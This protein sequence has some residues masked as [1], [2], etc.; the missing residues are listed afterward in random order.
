MSRS[1]DL[2]AM[3]PAWVALVEILARID[4]EPY[5][6][7]VGRI[8]FQKIAYFATESGLPTGLHYARGSYGPFAPDLKPLVTRLVNNGLI[9]EEE[10]GRMFVVKPGPTYAD[11]VRAYKDDLER[12]EPI[13]E[14]VVDLF[15]R[16]RTEQAEV[17]A[18]AHFAATVLAR[19]G[20][21]SP[22]ESDVLAEVKRWKQRRR[23]RSPT[24][25]SPPRF[26]ISTSWA[27]SECSRA[28]T[29]RWPRRP[30]PRSDE[31]TPSRAAMTQSE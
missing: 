11:A 25:R 21:S 5:H 27:G 22:A 4:R 8:M 16:M 3:E 9:R 13:I 19:E 14:R 29:C 1:V 31:V 10:H 30:W 28:R 20:T 17:A 7:P 2:P 15:L 18:T 12:W 6:W 24:R 23:P 26:A